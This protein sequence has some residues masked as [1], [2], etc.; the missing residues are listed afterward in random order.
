LFR[1]KPPVTLKTAPWGSA[2]DDP[3]E[4]VHAGL[5]GI[6]VVD[7]YQALLWARVFKA[8]RTKTWW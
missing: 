7:W 6:V 3:L 5:V 4:M 1:Q 8:C 2:G